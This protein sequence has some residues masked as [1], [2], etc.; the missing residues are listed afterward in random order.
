MTKMTRRIGRGVAAVAALGLVTT[1]AF[2]AKQPWGQSAM[3]EEAG[4]CE[5]YGIQV[6]GW[7]NNCKGLSCDYI[8]QV[9]NPT[10]KR[11]TFDVTVTQLEKNWQS[12]LGGA[13]KRFT[14]APYQFQQ[15]RLFRSAIDAPKTTA[16]VLVTCNNFE[17]PGH[18]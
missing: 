8:L 9:G 14:A 2:A 3:L 4:L 10:G 11:G 12:Y 7:I 18:H 5:Q 6:D 1:S 17:N 15:I 13:S 16:V